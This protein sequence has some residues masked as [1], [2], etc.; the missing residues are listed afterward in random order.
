MS[1]D[2]AKLV[3]CARKDFSCVTIIFDV[4]TNRISIGLALNVMPTNV[5]LSDY[6]AFKITLLQWRMTST[7]LLGIMFVES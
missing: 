1:G 6:T 5:S 7:G 4:V 3:I 2:N